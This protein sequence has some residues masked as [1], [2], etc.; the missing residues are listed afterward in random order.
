MWDLQPPRHISTLPK[1]DAT[2]V[3]R[4]QVMTAAWAASLTGLLSLSTTFIYPTAYIPDTIVFFL[5]LLLLVPA[6]FLLTERKFHR[7]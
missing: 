1:A 5:L 4:E 3:R 7:T 2:V 6:Y